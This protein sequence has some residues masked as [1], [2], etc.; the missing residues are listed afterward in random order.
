MKW[1]ILVACIGAMAAIQPT[2]AQSRAGTFET[3]LGIL[4]Q[5]S[6]EAEFNG[7]TQVEFDSDM[8]F[9]LGFAYHYTDN[10]EFGVNM[11]LGQTD[12]EAE[13]FGDEPG[14][15]FGVRGDLEYTTLTVDGTWN[16]LSGPFSPFLTATVGW[17]WVDTNIASGPPETG[18]WWDPWYGYICATWQDTRTV[19]GFTYGLGVGARY[20]ISDQ[21]AVHGSYR[22]DWIDLDEAQGTPDFDGFQLSVGWKF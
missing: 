15:S 13:I 2:A 1:T 17:T 21:F 19:D 11:G 14:E 9:K 22:I 7:G 4:V 20:D 10:L 12:Y 3:R 5:N 8:G 16:I 18:C 6:A